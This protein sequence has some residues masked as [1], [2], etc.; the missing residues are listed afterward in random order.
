MTAAEVM[1]TAILAALRF[2][3]NFEHARNMLK[4][5]GYMPGMLGKSRFQS[6]IA[7]RSKPFS[8]L[9]SP[10]S[11]TWKELNKEVHLCSG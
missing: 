7:S 2:G 4:T 10:T 8:D 5:E 3:G 6:A 11:E 1:T 9:V